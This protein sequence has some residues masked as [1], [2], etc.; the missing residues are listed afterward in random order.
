MNTY[1][2]KKGVVSE[3]LFRLRERRIHT[4]FPG[5][6]CLQR[7][8]AELQRFEDLQPDF[9]SF[10]NEY[11]LVENHPLGKPYIK[12]FTEQKASP[13]NLWLNENVA[14]S[15]APS[16]LRSDQPFRQVVE[17]DTVKKEY[18]L[19]VDHAIKAFKYLLFNNQI[20][21]VDLVIYLYRDYGLIDD[22]F[23]IYDLIE[24]FSYEFGYSS[25]RNVEFSNDFNTLFT[26]DR[27]SK[28]S[29]EWLEQI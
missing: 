19:P 23:S 15:Y 1:V 10:F 17:I 21:A 20:S 12:P 11:F 14:G 6:L 2:I 8:A 3:S 7:Q 27:A 24:V 18:S 22:S 28:W 9:R 5:Y 13:Q 25:Q 16:S 4:L 29:I 26:L